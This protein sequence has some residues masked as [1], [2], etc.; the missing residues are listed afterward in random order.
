MQAELAIDEADVII[1]VV[2]SKDGIT[3]EDSRWLNSKKS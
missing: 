1:L 3:H 2:D